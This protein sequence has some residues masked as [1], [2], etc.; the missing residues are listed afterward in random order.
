MSGAD[1]AALVRECSVAAL[2]EL[3]AFK[4]SQPADLKPV[5]ISTGLSNTSPQGLSNTSQGLSV[6]T[7]DNA[8]LQN[9]QTDIKE[10]VVSWRHVKI[11]L[12]NVKPSVSQ[13]D[14]VK[15][16]RLMRASER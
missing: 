11:A 4:Q 10:G 14:L 2:K 16:E 3:I 15:Y 12:K 13:G 1:L 8:D 9:M 5:Q 7:A 6:K